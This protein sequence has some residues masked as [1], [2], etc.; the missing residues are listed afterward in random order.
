MVPERRGHRAVRGYL[1]ETPP[2]FWHCPQN[3]AGLV[4][5]TMPFRALAPEHHADN[6]QYA[7]ITLKI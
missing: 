5:F 2:A 4:R 6:G 7:Q 1:D 3:S